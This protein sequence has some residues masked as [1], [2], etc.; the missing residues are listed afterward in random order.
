MKNPIQSHTVSRRFSRSAIAI[1]VGALLIVGAAGYSLSGHAE[2]PDA[3]SAAPPATPVTVA[4]VLERSIIEWDDFSGRV[5][6]VER[7]DIRPRVSGTI[8]A[9]HF[10]DG[11]LVKKGDKLFTIDQRPYKA[12]LAQAEATRAGA[13]ARAALTRTELERTRRLIEDRAVARRELDERE[14]AW[15]EAEANLKAAEAAVISARLNLQYTEITA[16]VSGR[17]SRAEIT[18][19]NLVATGPTAPTL[20]TVVSVSPVYVNFEIDEPTYIRY[21]STGAVGNANVQRIPVAIGLTSET[22]YPREGHVQSFDNRLDTGSGTIRVRAVFDNADGTLTPGMY[23]RVRTG[24]ANAKNAL[25]I[26]D[27][28]VG[29]DQD[30]KYVMVVGSD[31]KAVYRQITLGPMADGLRVVRGGLKKDERI[32]VN[33]LQRIRPNDAVTPEVVAMD[34]RVAGLN[35]AAGQMASA[36]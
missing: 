20:T 4:G 24:D 10:K 13:Q 2:K 5:E 29:T 6:S 17:V 30:K 7:V 15:H 9:V 8:E 1:A 32:V 31:N 35:K 3:A 16:P 23:A 26:D 11:Q 21:A 18:V 28:A 14:N 27:R 22:G 33:G 36:Q 34:A 12:E 19:G 25:L